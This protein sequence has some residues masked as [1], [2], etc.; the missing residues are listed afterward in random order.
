MAGVIAGQMFQFAL[1][2]AV[3]WLLA[4]RHVIRR[5]ALSEFIGVLQKVFLPC[6]IFDFVYDGMTPRLL[7]GHL[8]VL[9]LAAA[10]YAVLIALTWLLGK[11]MCLA[12]QRLAIFRMA[13]IF[14]NT[15]FIGVPLLAAVFPNSG[16]ADVALFL[17]IDS[18][19]LWTYGVDLGSAQHGLGRLTW[20][21]RLLGILNPNIIATYAAL[22]CVLANVRLPAPLAKCIA[23]LGGGATPLCMVVLGAL[24]CFAPMRQA[25]EAREFY[26]GVAVKMIV[27]PVLIGLALTRIPLFH[28]L[29]HEVVALV[30]VLA[31]LPTNTVVPL[32]AE[33]HGGDGD[34]ATALTVGSIIASAATI[35][36]VAWVLAL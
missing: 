10:L 12:A 3:G 24:C 16:G 35:P 7:A 14:G 23:T 1:M 21:E 15:S 30:V 17:L 25:L 6:M 33:S 27:L 36:L 22:I 32:I 26:G 34:Y 20:R 29:S 31:A 13:F 2:L 18:A 4:K 28:A 19:I 8:P 9:W 11:A 5:G